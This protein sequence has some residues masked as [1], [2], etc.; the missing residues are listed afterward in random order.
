MA[1]MLF[2]LWI[3]LHT[4]HTRDR[5]VWHMTRQEYSYMSTHD[6]L[7]HHLTKLSSERQANSSTP[8]YDKIS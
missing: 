1:L 2:M 4:V 5:A 7:S 6:T 3:W 8:K